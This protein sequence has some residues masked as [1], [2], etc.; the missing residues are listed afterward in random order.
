MATNDQNSDLELNHIGY[1]TGLRQPRQTR[2][3]VNHVNSVNSVNAINPVNPIT[4]SSK[5][6]ILSKISGSRFNLADLSVD[7][8]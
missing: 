1:R 4:P 5:F 6:P 2:Q 8:G 7:C 3:P